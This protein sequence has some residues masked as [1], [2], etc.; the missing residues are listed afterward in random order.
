MSKLLWAFSVLS[1]TCSLGNELLTLGLEALPT[2]LLVSQYCVCVGRVE[3][4]EAVAIAG[5][6][7]HQ[8]GPYC[9]TMLQRCVTEG[10]EAQ[11]LIRDLMI[12]VQRSDAGGQSSLMEPL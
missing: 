8:S 5:G 1:V 12:P 11:I 4:E 3:G 7:P 10:R 6:R 2:E 9:C